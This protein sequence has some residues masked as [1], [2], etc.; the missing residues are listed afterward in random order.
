MITYILSQIAAKG[1]WCLLKEGVTAF[2]KGVK[3]R[4]QKSNPNQEQTPPGEKRQ[5]DS[6]KREKRSWI[7]KIIFEKK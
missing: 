3:K 6:P 5:E 4:P 7:F 1:I 2:W